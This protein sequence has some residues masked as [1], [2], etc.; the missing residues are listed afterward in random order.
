MM[1]E[2]V[3]LQKNV[4]RMNRMLS[5][6][7]QQTGSGILSEDELSYKDEAAVELY[8]SD[9]MAFMKNAQTRIFDEAQDE[10]CLLQIADRGL[11][12]ADGALKRI[13]KLAKIV[14]FDKPR[15]KEL[16][17]IRAE[18][19]DLVEKV[20]QISR[21]TMYNEMSPLGTSPEKRSPEIVDTPK[22][23]V[24]A[25]TERDGG[26]MRTSVSKMRAQLAKSFCDVSAGKLGLGDLDLSSEKNSG[27]AADVVRKAMGRISE[28]RMS[29]DQERE[30]L[31][32]LLKD[33][34]EKKQTSVSNEVIDSP[35]KA[36]AMLNG[37]RDAIVRQKGMSVAAQANSAPGGAIQLLK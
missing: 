17:E 20:D 14:A 3:G 13:E 4:N 1:I 28:Y 35:K 30:R 10:I 27:R 37:S 22:E 8:I 23:Y 16:E 21:N 9:R 19:T 2:N 7:Q 11:S 5:D 26:F 31:E 15:D 24:R 33:L 6:G 25:T 36:T 34:H 18:V 12:E 29:F 32:K